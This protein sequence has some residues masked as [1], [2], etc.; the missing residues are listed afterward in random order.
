MTE[1]T[2]GEVINT[3][4]NRRNNVNFERAKGRLEYVL[5]QNPEIDPER[6]KVPSEIQDAV[7]FFGRYCYLE[8]MKDAAKL[9]G[10]GLALG[11]LTAAGIY[12][13]FA[14][15]EI[16][17]DWSEIAFSVSGGTSILSL[18][19]LGY[20]AYFLYTGIRDWKN[21]KKEKYSKPLTE[22]ERRLA[23]YVLMDDSQK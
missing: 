3:G 14:L 4:I 20:G 19:T 11:A 18:Q 10:G 9:I 5:K 21:F 16:H 17:S 2:L 15:Q 13:G 7:S 12:G 1:K 8:D 23:D 22:K 6:L